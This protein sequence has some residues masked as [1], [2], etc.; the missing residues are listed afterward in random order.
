MEPYI[1][2]DEELD[3]LVVKIPGWEIKTKQIEREFNLSLIH[4]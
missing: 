1:L 2:Q 3:E 4:I